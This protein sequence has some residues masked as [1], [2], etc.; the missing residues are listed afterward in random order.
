MPDMSVT[1]KTNDC[2]LDIS[3]A[4]EVGH[5]S[6]GNNL[7]L[8]IY[9]DGKYILETEKYVAQPV[10]GYNGVR[11]DRVFIPVSAGVHKVDLHWAVGAG[12][13]NTFG[14]RRLLQVR[15]V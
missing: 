15:E 8:I 13:G 2:V 12:T 14:I 7:Q 11:S 10:A 6:A 9:V 5:A 4:V 3:Y 1:V